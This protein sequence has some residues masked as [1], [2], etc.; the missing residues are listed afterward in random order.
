MALIICKGL[1]QLWLSVKVKIKG[2]VL[3]AW[4]NVL[5]RKLSVGLRGRASEILG[6]LKVN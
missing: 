5:S 4:T 1:K 3:T 6:K 2:Q